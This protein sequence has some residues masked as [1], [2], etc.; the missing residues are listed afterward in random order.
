MFVPSPASA[1]ISDEQR[2]AERFAP[3]VALVHQDTECGPGEPYQPSDVDAFLGNESVALR[4]PWD[5]DDLVKIAPTTDDLSKGLAGYHL[6]FPGNPLKPGC[7]YEL[8]ARV[9]TAGTPPTVYAHLATETGRNDRLALQYWFYYP[10]NDYNNKHES[11]WETVQLV[12]AAQ[13]AAEAL[14]Q[15]PVEVGYSQHEG[16][17]VARWGDPKLELVDGTHPVVRVAS[18]SHANYYDAALF[19][20]RSSQQGFGCDDT[21]TPADSVRPAVKLIPSDPAAARAALPWIAYEGRWGQR[22]QAFYNG[23]TGPG[24]KERWTNPISFEEEHGRDRSYAVPAGGLLGTTATDF[25]CSGVADGSDVVRKLADDPT[26]LLIGAGLLILVVS[27]LI[28]RTS[29]RP[30]APLRLAR[31]RAGGQVLAAAARMYVSRWTLFVP[32]GLVVIPAFL[33]AGALQSLIVGTPRIAG[34]AA[35]GEAGGLRVTVAALV[36]YVIVGIV[37]VAVLGATTRALVE[38][39]AEREVGPRRAYQLSSAHW[40]RVVGALLVSTILVALLSLTI[41][42]LPV[43]IALIV[44]FALFVP[45]V[46]LEGESAPGALRRSAQL[47]RHQILKVAALL[48]LSILLATAVGPLLGTLM[49]LATNAPFPLA[50]V[51][52]GLTFAFLMPYVALTMA[53]VYFDTLVREQLRR[54]EPAAPP[55]LPAELVS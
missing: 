36:S 26:P 28:R 49:I 32:I 22:E 46:E 19:L 30:T 44:A 53:Y 34:I 47:V 42:L 8:W 48:A 55:T 3:V 54:L 51:I 16:V 43:A 18:G 21:R 24:T 33:L 17:E 5:R 37:I 20:G 31:R 9:A 13:D 23:P 11:D 7:D 27:Y 52:A 39:D 50:N 40:R 41:V 45:V 14:T 38:I 29:W 12:F 10:F 4:G 25:F 1:G 15:Q 6:D 2:L 35:G